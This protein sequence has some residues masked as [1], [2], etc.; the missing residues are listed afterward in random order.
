MAKRLKIVFMGSAE[1]GLASLGALCA[2]EHEVVGVVTQPDRPGGRGRKMVPTT[3]K[4]VANEHGLHIMQPESVN[5]PPFRRRIAALEPDVFVVVAFGQI[6]GGKLL[7][8]PRLGAVNVHASLLPEYRGA[9]PINWAI[10]HGRK[11]T[12]ISIMQMVREMDA[13]DVYRRVATEIDPNEGADQLALR[14]GAISVEPLLDTLEEIAAGTAVAAPQDPLLVTIAPKLTKRTGRLVLTRPAREL[15]NLIRG[16]RPWP[17]GYV[18]FTAAATGKSER[19]TI[20]QSRVVED[21]QTAA[22]AATTTGNI[23]PGTVVSLKPL[24]VRTGESFLQL[25]ELKPA[26]ARRMADVDFING[27]R[28]QIGDRF[29]TADLEGDRL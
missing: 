3:V 23:E 27:R 24:I 16:T 2:S 13:G 9:G 8:I 29:T 10:I 25:V 28:V 6:L 17:Q 11:R 15:H 26:G 5:R 4:Q 7:A 21:F 14:L 22:A 19:V 1:I 18:D 12:G 20:C